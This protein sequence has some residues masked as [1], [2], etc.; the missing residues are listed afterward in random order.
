MLVAILLCGAL[1]SIYKLSKVSVPISIYLMIMTFPY[2]SVISMY[3]P[4]LDLVFEL[5]LL[6]QIIF[7]VIKR[8]KFGPKLRVFN[9][10]FFFVAFLI[11]ITLLYSLYIGDIY[12]IF[13]S[14]EPRFYIG[15]FLLIFYLDN[16]T[17]NFQDIININ[18]IFIIN[19][20]LLVFFGLISWSIGTSESL[21]AFDNKNI[22]AMEMVL[23]ILFC[24]YNTRLVESK[25]IKRVY[26]WG[27][28][29]FGLAT[30]FT[31]SAAAIIALFII[32]CLN[33]LKILKIRRRIFYKIILLVMLF[34]GFMAI[35]ITIDDRVMDSF[36]I[37]SI[38]ETKGYYDTTRIYI[39]QEAIQRFKEHW[40]IG[41]GAD[42]FRSMS[43]DY[44]YATHNDYL[45]FLVNYGILG[46]AVFAAYSISVVY[47]VFKTKD[48]D[49]FLI[50]FMLFTSIYVYILSH[51]FANY[52]VFWCSIEILN[53]V[54]R[55][56]N[57]KYGGYK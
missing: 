37:R 51:N 35:Y 1:I 5:L 27:A 18:K 52:I 24:M 12:F 45:S 19:G 47:K 17:I 56:S 33:I 38:M 26:I 13:S 11:L 25:K 57:R 40:I 8:E 3:C 53:C 20:V 31:K 14:P 21:Y 50:S 34:C 15:T 41:I 36:I 43:L 44:P 49:L 4:W 6:F 22:Y 46:F 30:L 9:E 16:T 7:F 55:I 32:I 42:N 29:L 10:M 23:N 2:K 48:Y 54:K 39:W 28:C